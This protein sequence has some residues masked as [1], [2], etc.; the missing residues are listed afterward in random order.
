M[1]DTV[2]RIGIFPVK[3]HADRFCGSDGCRVR[4][5]TIGI[6]R[7][8]VCILQRPLQDGACRLFGIAHALLIPA[9]MEADL[10]QQRSADHLERQTA[11]PDEQPCLFQTDNAN[12]LRCC[13]SK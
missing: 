11:V 9:D 1:R 3:P 7:R 10:R 2:D 5:F 6:K 4:G 8:I 12:S 13:A